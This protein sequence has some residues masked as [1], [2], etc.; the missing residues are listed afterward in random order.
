MASERSGTEGSAAKT[1]PAATSAVRMI[2]RLEGLAAAA[3]TA[4]LYARTG[5]SWWLFAALW[6]APDLSLLG[7]LGSAKTGARVYNAIHSYITPA[8]LALAALLLRSA[9]LLPFALIWINHIGVDRML[10]YG[11]KYP[12]G[13]KWTHLGMLGGRRAAATQAS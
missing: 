10:G 13:F 11:L 5:A 8:T 3:L 1:A 7:Y 6:L 9:A 4:V 2:L 12:E